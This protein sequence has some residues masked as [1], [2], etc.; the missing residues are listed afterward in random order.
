MYTR[1]RHRIMTSLT[2]FYE[3]FFHLQLACNIASAI[4][5]W[6]LLLLA[7]TF[8][9]FP[10]T[11]FCTWHVL[12]TVV[13]SLPLVR[14][15]SAELAHACTQSNNSMPS[16]FLCNFP[17]TPSLAWLS[18]FLSTKA[19]PFRFGPVKQSLRSSL[20]SESLLKCNQVDPCI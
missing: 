14:A 3:L 9:L 5:P 11:C 20:L 15:W 13:P 1:N 2:L 12:I 18:I 17:P 8:P 16:S 10:L 7:V 19:D 4:V 6:V